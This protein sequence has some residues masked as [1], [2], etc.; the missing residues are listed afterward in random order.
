MGGYRV[1]NSNKKLN[2]VVI[3]SQEVEGLYQTKFLAEKN[4]LS[5]NYGEIIDLLHDIIATVM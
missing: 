5:T 1:V 2:R 4:W 3:N